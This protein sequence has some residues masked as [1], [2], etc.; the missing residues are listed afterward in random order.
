MLGTMNEPKMNQTRHHESKGLELAR[1]KRQQ[2]H[3]TLY[4]EAGKTGHVGWE[5][6]DTMKNARNFPWFKKKKKR[7]H[8][9]KTKSTKSIQ[10]GHSQ[11][12]HHSDHQVKLEQEDLSPA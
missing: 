10:N 9:N 2:R 12:Q 5:Q 3:Y 7:K 6:D 11:Q 8:Q 1:E 4:K